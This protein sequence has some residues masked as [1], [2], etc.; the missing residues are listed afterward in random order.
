M[1]KLLSLLLVLSLLLC[2][3]LFSCTD[4]PEKDKGDKDDN[5]VNQKEPSKSPEDE[6]KEIKDMI[7]FLMQD[8]TYDPDDLVGKYFGDFYIDQF[9]GANPAYSKIYK[10]GDT[11]GVEYPNNQTTYQITKNSKLFSIIRSK[12]GA[13]LNLQSEQDYPYAYPLSIFTAFGIDMSAAYSGEESADDE[14]AL[15][16]DMITLSTTKNEAVFSKDYLDGIAKSL[17]ASFELDDAALNKFLSEMSAVGIFNVVTM[18]ADF[19]IEGSIDGVGKVK[20][21]TE[22][23]FEK[24]KPSRITSSFQIDE[25]VDGNP[26]TNK[27]VT[28]QSFTYNGKEMASVLIENQTI[29]SQDSAALDY[30]TTIDS[31]YLFKLKDS[32]PEVFSIEN[33]AMYTM[34]IAG[35]VQQ[36]ETVVGIK[37]GNKE[38]TYKMTVDGVQQ[39]EII[40]KNAVINTPENITIPEDIYTVLPK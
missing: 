35:L 16:H 1:R 12:D 13:V 33:K 10:L 14:P 11:L 20:F 15:T 40:A 31:T 21:E 18:S 17:C 27:V 29:S 34:T 38:L 6:E 36:S 25:T 28:T 3:S 9:D 37:L 23:V 4:L 7:I 32:K 2:T 5:E 24:T 19:S 30:T 26:A 39:A 8:D 22:F